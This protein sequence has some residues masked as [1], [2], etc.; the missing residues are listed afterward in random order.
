MTGWAYVADI[1]A[2][3]GGVASLVAVIIGVRALNDTHAAR[4]GA[5]RDRDRQRL[6]L[7][8]Q[9][10]DRMRSAAMADRAQVPERNDWRE[11]VGLLNRYLAASSLSLPKLPGG[12]QQAQ[13]RRGTGR[14]SCRRCRD[15]PGRRTP[16]RRSRRA[17]LRRGH[18]HCG[19]GRSRIARLV[20]CA[21]LARP[22]RDAGLIG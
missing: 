11:G 5:A 12:R 22:S 1:A 3:V 20:G 16:F 9:H 15:H 19:A 4:L 14:Y 21:R 8:A 2:A 13:R 6:E 18:P 7:V 10:L 17:H